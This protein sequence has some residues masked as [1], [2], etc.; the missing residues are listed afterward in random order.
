MGSYAFVAP[1]KHSNDHYPKRPAGIKE[2]PVLLSGFAA[3]KTT[4]DPIHFT[5][6]LSVAIDRYIGH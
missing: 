5:P 3:S 2:G 4:Y 1:P 6:V